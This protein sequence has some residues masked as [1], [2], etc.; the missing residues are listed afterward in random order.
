M[1]ETTVE[2]EFSITNCISF[3]KEAHN[4][5]TTHCVNSCWKALWPEMVN[6]VTGFPTGDQDVRQIIQL[7]WEEGDKDSTTYN[8]RRLWTSF[9]MLVKN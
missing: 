1:C 3:I 2:V 5:L 9:I 6:D 8:Q 4:D 7:A